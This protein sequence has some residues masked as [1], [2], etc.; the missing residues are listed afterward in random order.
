MAWDF[1]I[2]P[3]L[4]FGEWLH[5]ELKEE[6]A[7]EKPGWAVEQVTQ[8]AGRLQ[9]RRLPHER[10]HVEVA[11]ISVPTAFTAPGRYIYFNRSLLE[12]CPH[13]EAVAFV[14]AH[15][16][17]HHDLGHL[18]LFRGWLS[19]LLRV[20]M[21]GVTLAVVFQIVVRRLYGPEQ[22]CDA[23]L[24]A[25]Q[26]CIDAGYDPHKCLQIFDTLES[27]ALD[28]GDVDIVFGPDVDSD[29]ELAEDADWKTK[30]Q[31]WLWQ[32]VRGY[33]PI[34]DRKAALLA[35]LKEMGETGDWIKW[36]E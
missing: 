11:W 25:L 10:L 13:D 7:F 4:T 26:L 20:G 28:A 16:M 36:L 18:N 17:A 3:G 33:L 9:R 31:I 12:V 32:R 30:F 23:D 29:D 19:S 24:H 5:R 8:V 35:Y 14:I 15:E 22:E 27:L 21:S 6:L 2:K 34:R 1:E